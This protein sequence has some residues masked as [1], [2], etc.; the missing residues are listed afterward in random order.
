MCLPYGYVYGLRAS[1][2]SGAQIQIGAGRCRDSANNVDIE[3]TAALIINI[4]S[5]GAN[6][7]GT[8]SETANTWYHL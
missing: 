6:G 7:L 1:F 5:S 2:V 8:G 3:V 4:K